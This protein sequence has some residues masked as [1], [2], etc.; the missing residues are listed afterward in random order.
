MCYFNNFQICLNNTVWVGSGSASGLGTLKIL[1]WIRNKSFRIQNTGSRYTYYYLLLCIRLASIIHR[2]KGNISRIKTSEK[3]TNNVKMSQNA[4]ETGIFKVQWGFFFI[5]ADNF[6]N[7]S[8]LTRNNG[9][10]WFKKNKR[11]IIAKKLFQFWNK[12][13]LSWQLSNCFRQY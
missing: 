10:Q 9:Q 2:G 3:P 6:R 5:P 8:N 12:N 13:K 11:E 1:S 4:A 7:F